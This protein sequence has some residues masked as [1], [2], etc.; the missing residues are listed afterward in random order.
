MLNFAAE[1]NLD[2]ARVKAAWNSFSVQTRC[3]E[4]RRLEDDYGIERMPEMAIAGRYVAIA[5]PAAGPASVLA[6][7]DWLVDKVRRRA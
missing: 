6:T 7:T 1:S 3:A 4:A 2:P 5:Q